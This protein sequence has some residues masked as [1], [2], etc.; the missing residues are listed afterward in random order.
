MLLDPRITPYY[1]E[2]VAQLEYLAKLDDHVV[3]GPTHVVKKDGELLGYISLGSIP[4]VL[5]WM[6]T[7][8]AKVRDSL[9]VQN[10]IENMARNGGARQLCIPC[11][12]K[13]PC[14]PYMDKLGYTSYGQQD[15]M[16]K[17]I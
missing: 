11:A 14:R 6:D 15:L 5:L 4:M 17:S 13:S 3:V 1:P 8:R 2:D 12:T 10:F 9:C 16:I 7:K